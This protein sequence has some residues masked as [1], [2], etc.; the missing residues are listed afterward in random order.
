MSSQNNNTELKK[1]A[2]KT[3][4][5]ER[6]K[7]KR[8]QSKLQPNKKPKVQ[9]KPP[10]SEKIDSDSRPKLGKKPTRKSFKSS[11]RYKRR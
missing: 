1:K 4:K 6:I 8:E 7:R 11:K 2:F 9:K 5:I 10:Q 3:E